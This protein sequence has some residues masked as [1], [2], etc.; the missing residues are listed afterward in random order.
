MEDSTI[1]GYF[2]FNILSGFL[3]GGFGSDRRIGFFASF[4][5]TVFLSPLVGLIVI[6]TSPTLKDLAIQKKRHQELTQAKSGI[7][8][9]EELERLIRLRDAGELTV[10]EFQKM[11]GGLV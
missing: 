4:I 9:A 10:E 11:K 6:L 8:K 5:I 2:L 7:S 3:I 1:I